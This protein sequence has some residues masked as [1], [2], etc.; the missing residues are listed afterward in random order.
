MI[1]VTAIE[2]ATAYI[3]T[4]TDGSVENTFVYEW[5]KEPPDGQTEEEYLQSCKR[6]AELLAADAIGRLQ[7]PTPIEL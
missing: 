5:G 7:P 6:E 4:T 2:T 1:T 3:F